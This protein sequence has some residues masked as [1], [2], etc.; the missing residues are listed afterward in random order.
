LALAAS[1]DAL[2]VG[3]TFAVLEV[4]II[5]AST[6]IGAITFVISMCGVKTGNLFGLKF[7]SKAEFSGGAILILL[8]VKI[9]L[10]HTITMSS[11]Y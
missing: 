6:L 8:G 10:E 7:K 2:A 9:D 11:P 5:M 4:Q 3:I 1:I